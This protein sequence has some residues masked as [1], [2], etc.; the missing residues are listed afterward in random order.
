MAL[1]QWECTKSTQTQKHQLQ[2]HKIKI[3]ISYG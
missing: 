3:K 2:G 1:V